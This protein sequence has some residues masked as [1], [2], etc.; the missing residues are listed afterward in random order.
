MRLFLMVADRTILPV[1][2][3]PTVSLTEFRSFLMSTHSLPSGR[4]TFVHE[5]H[6]LLPPFPFKP[7]QENSRVILIIELPEEDP[8]YHWPPANPSV[9]ARGIE[10]EEA[11]FA[12]LHLRELYDDSLSIWRNPERAQAAVEALRRS[13]SLLLHYSNFMRNHQSIV[14]AFPH[15]NSFFPLTLLGYVPR[16]PMVVSDAEMEIALLPT[17]KKDACRHLVGM[18]FEAKDVLVAMQQTNFDEGAALAILIGWQA[19]S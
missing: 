12:N 13:P 3:S 19:G 11:T 5:G 1:N 7:L 10:T 15:R 9:Q 2:I 4:Y 18:E 8:R 6:I 17:A 14:A 16:L